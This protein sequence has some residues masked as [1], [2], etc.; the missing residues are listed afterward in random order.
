MHFARLNNIFKR[1]NNLIANFGYLSIFQFVNLL[2]PLLTYPYLIRVIGS[3][4]YGRIIYA[5]SIIAYFSILINY[6]FNISATK[7]VSIFRNDKMKLTEIL[8]SIYIIKT[9]IFLLSFLLLLILVLSVQ[10]FGKYKILYLFSFG[11]CFYELIFPV[12]YFQGVEKIKYITLISL[13]SRL[14]Y[15]ALI[16]ILIRRADDYLLVPLLNFIG[17]FISGVLTIYILLYKENVNLKWQSKETI[18]HYFKESRPF[19]LSRFSS[20][21]ISRTNTIIIGSFIGYSEVSYY[22][23]GQKILSVLLIPFDI[24]NQV[25]YPNIAVSKNMI[26]VRNLLKYVLAISI[27]LLVFLYITKNQ[28]ILFLGGVSML[29]SSTIVMLVCLTLLPI[30]LSYFLG[31]TVLVVMGYSSEFN[32]SVIYSSILFVLFLFLLYIIGF[33]NIY[34]LIVVS[35]IVE[36]VSM[37][38]RLYYIK[39]Y[40]LIKI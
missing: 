32:K 3:D 24:A 21:V 31:N 6:G 28:V 12:F 15:V 22:D 18:K 27:L 14:I 13:I 29:P 16:F 17:A 30:S 35:L 40:S 10:E 34:S 7:D 4:V 9:I 23:L 38:Y 25:I 36:L 1:N 20:V 39:K 33:I 8:S 2:L 19:F 37:C 11:A 5:Q 26:F